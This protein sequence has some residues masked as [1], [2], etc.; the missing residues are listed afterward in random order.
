LVGRA[1]QAEY[2]ELLLTHRDPSVH[3]AVIAASASTVSEE[4]MV[5][6]AKQLSKHKTELE[7][8]MRILEDHNRQLEAQLQRLH[9]LLDHVSTVTL[10]YRPV[11]VNVCVCRCVCDCPHLMSVFMCLCPCVCIGSVHRNEFRTS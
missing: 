6:E 11:D 10:H 9:L 3:P 7:V 5:A 2:D 4:E 1:L 8:R